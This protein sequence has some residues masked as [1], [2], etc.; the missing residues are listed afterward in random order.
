MAAI[1][2]TVQAD[3]T[4]DALFRA[5]GSTIAAQMTA[6]GWVQTSDTGQINWTTV[7]KPVSAGVFSGY[8]IWR[9]ADTLQATKPIF[10]KIEYGAAGANAAWPAIAC[11]VG[12][13]TS[14]AGAL[15]G[16]ISDR[17][18]LG[19]AA[20]GVLENALFSG[21][22][23]RF[24]I[25]IA[26]SGIYTRHFA[27]AVER[28]KDVN[29]ADTGDGVYITSKNGNT[30]PAQEYYQYGVGTAGNESDLGIFIPRI[31]TGASGANYG[32]FPQHHALGVFLPYGL[33]YFGYF[34]AVITANTTISFSVYGA[35]HT[36]Y[37]LPQA[38]LA[39]SGVSRGQIQT[40]VSA[41]VRFE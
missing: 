14:G 26:F 19:S 3:N 9:M 30:Q 4:T 18:V 40:A 24:C 35:T 21:S 37:T 12:I 15:V 5:W 27:F 36:Y 31:G 33:N 8:E 13:A 25:H 39:S 7:A 17:F 32:V 16:A 20:A 22:T 38:Q 1:I 34:T 28:S 29:G 41:L 2:T 23:N 11:T 6:F 10:V